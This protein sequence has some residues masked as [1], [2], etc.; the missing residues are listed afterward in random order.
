MATLKD[1]HKEFII[2]QLACYRSPSEV[3]ELVRINYDLEVSTSQIAY[4]DPDTVRS[5]NLS[6]KW[7]R[8]HRSTRNDYL[9]E[10]SKV[11]IFHKAYRLQEM[12]QNYNKV[13]KSGNIS[14]AQQILVEAAKEAGGVYEG[15]KVEEGSD[16]SISKSTYI[17]E[18]YERIENG[19]T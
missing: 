2:N 8:M 4:Y 10:A 16:T 17:Q 18:I 19:G 12:Q 3:Q 14:L 15:K 9:E 5:G 11:P 1:N 6:E 7:R 13:K